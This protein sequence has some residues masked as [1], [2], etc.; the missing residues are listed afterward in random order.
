MGDVEAPLV[1]LEIL[2]GLRPLH[3]LD[4]AGEA[5]R[6]FIQKPQ[7][8]DHLPGRGVVVLLELPVHVLRVQA[9]VRRHDPAS[10]LPVAVSQHPFDH[11]PGNLVVGVDDG[12]LQNVLIAVAV[13]AGVP[14]HLPAGEPVQK[15]H[16]QRHLVHAGGDPVLV[17]VQ[18]VLLPGDG[19]IVADGHVLGIGAP[20]LEEL[21]HDL[22][23]ILARKALIVLAHL[24][25]RLLGQGR[26]QSRQQHQQR[27]QQTYQGT[28]PSHMV[29]LQNSL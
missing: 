1:A 4:K 8:V 2:C 18:I 9:A 6:V 21:L 12:L 15:H 26:G 11:A 25:L 10:R 5:I 28:D 24:G 29:S 23:P 17:R 14:V 27:Q 7:T 13:H 16:V 20:A 19:V 22:V 3:G